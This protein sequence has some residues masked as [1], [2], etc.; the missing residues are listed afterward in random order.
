[1]S[2]DSVLLSLFESLLFVHGLSTHKLMRNHVMWLLFGPLLQ[3]FGTK[4]NADV[5]F[6]WICVYVY[7]NNVAYFPQCCL[8]VVVVFIQYMG[9]GFILCSLLYQHLTALQ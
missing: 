1:M 8:G 9:S 4:I 5:E 7:M 3:M 6:V 2:I